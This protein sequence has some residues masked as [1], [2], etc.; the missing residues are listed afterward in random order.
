MLGRCFASFWVCNLGLFPG[1]EI[2]A[3][4]FIQVPGD[5]LPKP[6]PPVANWRGKRI[7]ISV[8]PYPSWNATDPRLQPSGKLG[9]GW[10]LGRIFFCVFFRCLE[11]M[12]V[13]SLK[14]FG[15]QVK[16][17]QR[18]VWKVAVCVF[19]PFGSKSCR[20]VGQMFVEPEANS[21]SQWKFQLLE[22]DYISFGPFEQFRP[23][24]RGLIAVRF[25]EC[26]SFCWVYGQREML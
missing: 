24:S 14:M 1:F 3:V 10:T 2:V 13:L 17:K 23:T 9:W 16:S 22:D 18:L 25:K 26:D 8:R 15:F 5:S 20:L 12:D 19:D 21:K 11:Q 4:S 7:S 6:R